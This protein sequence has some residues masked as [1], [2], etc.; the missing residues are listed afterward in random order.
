MFD[1]IYFRVEH[2]Q[3]V[4]PS[5]AS[6]VKARTAINY[7]RS[8]CT[9]L[10]H[11]LP[12]YSSTSAC[13]PRTPSLA[14]DQ[15]NKWLSSTL[16]SK[17]GCSLFS[18]V[19]PCE[20][21]WERDQCV[22]LSAASVPFFIYLFLATLFQNGLSCPSSRSRGANFSRRVRHIL[23]ESFL[24]SKYR[25]KLMDTLSGNTE[26][27]VL[28]THFRWHSDNS[29]IFALLFCKKMV[30]DPIESK[31]GSSVSI[32]LSS[33]ECKTRVWCLQSCC[34]LSSWHNETSWGYVA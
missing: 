9:E 14:W 33:R 2:R 27:T 21:C 34:G 6:Q 7:L 31:Q 24:F 23:W 10:L 16:C 11:T 4:L 25:K 8:E 28:P 3:C 22:L 1:N 13:V 5:P 18:K 30:N 20:S 15:Q 12:F 26:T 19:E 29:K 32:N 17:Q